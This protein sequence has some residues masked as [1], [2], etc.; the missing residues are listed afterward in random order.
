MMPPRYGNMHRTAGTGPSS[1]MAAAVVT[2]AT[3]AQ[4]EK[5]QK[6]ITPT[7]TE[8]SIKAKKLCEM[9]TQTIALSSIFASLD[10][11]AYNQ[12]PYADQY[13]PTNADTP[14][15]NGNGNSNG[16][17]NGN[18]NSNGNLNGIDASDEQVVANNNKINQQQHGQP[19]AIV[20]NTT[21][22][23]ATAIATATATA[24]TTTAAATAAAE[25]P[26]IPAAA[27]TTAT[28]AVGASDAAATM[29]AAPNGSRRAPVL[30][31]NL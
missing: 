21:S 10:C 27:M 2:A 8:H 19:N 17:G 31:T 12:I 14:T 24:I 6:H 30:Q 13:V 28:I 15:A 20:A 26:A 22:P 23:V 9:A 7:E 3:C 1:M 25:T 4:E 29:E 16:N 5:I 18:S 11:N